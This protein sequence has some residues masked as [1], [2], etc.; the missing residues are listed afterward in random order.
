MKKE[1]LKI[2][3]I[4][5]SSW[6]YFSGDHSANPNHWGLSLKKRKTARRCYVGPQGQGSGS[7]LGDTP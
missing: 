4:L 6:L 3:K 2:Q 1:K 7:T 5:A